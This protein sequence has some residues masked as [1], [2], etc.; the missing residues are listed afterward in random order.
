MQG[1]CA[2]CK[3][4]DL[5]L[6]AFCWGQQKGERLLAVRSRTDSYC[7]SHVAHHRSLS[8]LTPITL[9]IGVPGL[10]FERTLRDLH[11]CIRFPSYLLCNMETGIVPWNIAES[12]YVAAV[13]KRNDC[14]ANAFLVPP[15]HIQS[16]REAKGLGFP[17]VASGA[18]RHRN[19]EAA[20]SS[21]ASYI[22]IQ[23]MTE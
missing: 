9:A 6:F 19:V 18:G 8:K 14:A 23:G 21:L 1:F 22:Y 13:C 4:S 12:Q 5:G 20:R 16:L 3:L 7:I 10:T 11:C 15:V 17:Y 2:F